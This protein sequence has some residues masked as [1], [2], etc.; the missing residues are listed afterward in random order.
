MNL[1]DYDNQQNDYNDYYEHDKR[2]GGYA[3]RELQ[4][5][6]PKKRRKKTSG[7]YTVLVVSVVLLVILGATLAAEQKPN[8]AAA[9]KPVKP[10]EP[11]QSGE[12]MEAYLSGSTLT[13]DQLDF[14]KELTPEKEYGTTNAV[15]EE[16]ASSA[17]ENTPVSGNQTEQE[18]EHEGQTLVVK[19]DGT[20]QWIKINPYLTQNQYDYEGLVYQSPIMKYF[21]DS[22]NISYMGVDVSKGLGT[23]DYNKLKKAGVQFVMVKLGARGYGN[24]QLVLDEYFEKN[25]KAASEAGLSLGVYFFSQAVNEEEAIEEASFLLEELKDYNITYPVAYDMEEIKGDTARIDDLTQEERT[26]IARAFLTTVSAAGYKTM[27]YGNKEW[28]LQ[29]INLSLLTEFDIWLSQETVL[30]DYPYK[31]SMWQYSK[32]GSID[33]IAGKADLNISFINYDLK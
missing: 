24:G 3:G 21:E 28:L 16:G 27:I 29:K 25:M 32:N 23:V 2:Y 9:V 30:P 31:F 33:G 12:D 6:Y 4:E 26:K 10:R 1:R 17:G 15:G 8:A 5:S 7:V 19:A 11:V 22:E 20:E 18:D 14:W 13:S